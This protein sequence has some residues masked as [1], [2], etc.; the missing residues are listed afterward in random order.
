MKMSPLKTSNLKGLRVDPLPETET[1]LPAEEE[2]PE[3]EEKRIRPCQKLPARRR[4]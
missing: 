2:K 3:G 4:H 1:Q